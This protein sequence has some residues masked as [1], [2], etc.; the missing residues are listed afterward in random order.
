[1]ILFSL[2]QGDSGLWDSGNGMT[3]A[4]ADDSIVLVGATSGDWAGAT[5]GETDF[6]AVKVDSN[7]KEVWRWQASAPAQKINYQIHVWYI[8]PYICTC[9]SIG[10]VVSPSRCNTTAIHARV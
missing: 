9:L 1:M 4:G 6:A 10:F 7:G 5:A 2:E 3:M 8:I